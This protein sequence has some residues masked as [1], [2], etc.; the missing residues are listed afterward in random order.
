MAVASWDDVRRIGARL[1]EVEEAASYHRMPALKA[2]G[3]PFCRLWSPREHDRDG[4]HDTAVVVFCDLEDKEALLA[5]FPEAVFTTSHYDG[6]PALLVRLAD[7][8]DDLLAELLED[9]YRLR[10]PKR[11]VA[12]LDEA[13]DPS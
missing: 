6:H 1:P 2:R 10:A 11:L 8:D 5:T 4:V 7:V 3:R 12:Q 9:S 13:A